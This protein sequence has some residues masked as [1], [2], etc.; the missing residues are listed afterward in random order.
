MFSKTKAYINKAILTWWIK[1]TVHLIIMGLLLF[2]SAQTIRWH[3]AWFYLSLSACLTVANATV[4]CTDLMVERSKFQISTRK[5][6]KWLYALIYFWGPIAIL[7]TAGLEHRISSR[8]LIPIWLQ[9]I[10]FLIILF[11]GLLITWTF[12]VNPFYTSTMRIQ[13]EREHRLISHGPYKVVRHPGYLGSII[14][15]LATPV[16]LG[17]LYALILSFG[18]ILGIILRTYIED[19]LLTRQFKGYYNYTKMVRFKLIPRIW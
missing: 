9:L 8:S 4:M 2:S 3:S 11:G 17:S 10:A 1:Q 13:Y 12:S 19:M 5:W 14:V 7:V 6:D 15:T 16:A 18:V